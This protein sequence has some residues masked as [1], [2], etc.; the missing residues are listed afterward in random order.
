[1]TR[2]EALQPV[3]AARDHRHLPAVPRQ[4]FDQAGKHAAATDDEVVP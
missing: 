1:M 2:G 3:A 4:A